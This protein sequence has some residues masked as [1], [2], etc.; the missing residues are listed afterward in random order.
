MNARAAVKQPTGLFLL[1][2]PGNTFLWHSGEV[3]ENFRLPLLL[4]SLNGGRLLTRLPENENAFLR[5]QRRSY[6]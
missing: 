2:L 6:D 3:L 5:R 4:Y 1:P